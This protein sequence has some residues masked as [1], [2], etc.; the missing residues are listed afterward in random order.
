MS[1]CV[2]AQAR[3]AADLHREPPILPRHTRIGSALASALIAAALLG[4]VV[5]GLTMTGDD[6]STLAQG[7][8]AAGA[9]PVRLIA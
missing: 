4:G 5:V 9:N 1:T 8:G 7:E 6:P 2:N 3:P